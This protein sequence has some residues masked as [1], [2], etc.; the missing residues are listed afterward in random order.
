[1]AA[2]QHF[3]EVGTWIAGRSSNGVRDEVGH[4]EDR[5]SAVE[6]ESVAMDYAR[7][8]AWQLFALHHGDV[9]PAAFEITRGRQ[10]GQSGRDYD[11]RVHVRR[12]IMISNP[13]GGSVT[14]RV[15]LLDL[16]NN[17]G[18]K[19]CKGVCQVCT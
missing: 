4:G 15:Q 3:A 13:A 5:R 11:N 9:L 16:R 7:A 14:R 1:V 2:L 17:P 8:A 6:S 19:T 12:P 18:A 10:A